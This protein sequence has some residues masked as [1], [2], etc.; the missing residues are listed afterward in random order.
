MNFYQKGFQSL[1][2]EF[3]IVSLSIK[4]EVPKWLDGFFIRN[5]PAQFET[6]KNNFLHWFD[7]LGMLHKFNFENSKISY[8]NRFIESRGYLAEKAT[9]KIEYN[10]FAT[11]PKQSLIKH[12]L[13]LFS[14]PKFSQNP[15]ITIQNI[16]NNLIALSETPEY[17]KINHKTLKTEGFLNFSKD[18]KSE[19]ELAHTIYDRK[20]NMTYNVALKFG[21]KSSYL[22]YKIPKNTLEKILVSKIPVK[23]PAY[24]HSFCITE[25]YVILIEQPLRVNPLALKLRRKPFI[26]NY[27]W[28]NYK[29]AVFIIIDKKTGSIIDRIT[30]N[31]FLFFHIVNSFDKNDSIFI[32]MPVY[33]NNEIIDAFYLNNLRS[34]NSTLIPTPI[35]NRYEINLETSAISYNKINSGIIEL[36]TINKSYT[37]SKNYTYGYGVSVRKN[38]NDN[39]F[40]S[41]A[42]FNVKTGVS[43]YYNKEHCYYQE[44]MFVPN[45]N[46]KHED[47]G[48][49]MCIELNGI[50][51]KSY[52]I[53][54][55]AS[56]FKEIA[57]AEL[58][59]IIPFGFHG[60]WFNRDEFTSS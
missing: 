56:G 32:D 36:P 21:V 9:G 17:V 38:Q 20:E 28:K 47:D 42:K 54:L 34:E 18:I 25:K 11:A 59:G 55:D 40:N 15:N 37:S 51:S 6:E 27:K 50:K 5:G 23:K 2:K 39:F 49:V 31:S 26:T 14:N 33:N 60:N 57:R 45:P 35:L 53:L 44:P 16:N 3:D 13:T 8:K 41:L 52:I 1:D 48:V 46:Q 30:T 12:L 58:P 7:G 10:E 24:M 19:L 22:V 4:G 43:L 29:A